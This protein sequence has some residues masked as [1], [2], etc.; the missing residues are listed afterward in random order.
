MQEQHVADMQDRQ[1]S[2]EM[3]DTWLS[4][5][6]SSQSQSSNDR[7]ITPPPLTPSRRPTLGKRMDY[8]PKKDAIDD[9]LKMKFLS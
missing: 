9:K 5:G 6:N 1:I 2:D 8:G 4:S 7:I 3:E